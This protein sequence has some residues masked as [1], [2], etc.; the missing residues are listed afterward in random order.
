M[1]YKRRYQKAAII[2][3]QGQPTLLYAH[4]AFNNLLEALEQKKIK[5]FSECR[6]GFCGA[7]KTKVNSGEV[8]Y[9]NEPLAHL[10]PGECLPCCCAPDGDL[11]LDLPATTYQ[12]ITQNCTDLSEE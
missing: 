1:T 4:Q 10:E 11:D 6:N 3:L 7:C 5:V 8:F 2:S 9:I 12:G